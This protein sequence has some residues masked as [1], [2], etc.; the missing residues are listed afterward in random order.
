MGDSVKEGEHKLNSSF[1][2][3]FTLN[4]SP[5]SPVLEISHK[6]LSARHLLQNLLGVLVDVQILG[7][8]SRWREFYYLGLGHEICNFGSSPRWFFLKKCMLTFKNIFPTLL[9]LFMSTVAALV[10]DPLFLHWLF[11]VPPYGPTV[12][13]LLMLNSHDFQT[14]MLIC[15]SSLLPYESSLA[16]DP[17]HCHTS[18]P[19]S[20]TSQVPLP[21]S[22]Q[23]LLSFPLPPMPFLFLSIRQ[24]RASAL[25]PAQWPPPLWSPSVSSL[26]CPFLTSFSQRTLFICSICSNSVLSLL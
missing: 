11:Q 14:L 22:P 1:S 19:I 24:T 6:E 8:Y 12:S 4:L 9:V 26:H 16:L 3:T 15:L 2:F 10:Q 13:S 17:S 7:S 20:W 23:L 5:S 25:S 18:S 21:H